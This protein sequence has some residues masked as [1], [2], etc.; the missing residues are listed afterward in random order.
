MFIVLNDALMLYKLDEVRQIR[1]KLPYR[2]YSQL[3]IEL[4]VTS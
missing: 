3:V 1:A 4:S 2:V